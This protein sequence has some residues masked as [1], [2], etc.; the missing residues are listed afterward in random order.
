[1]EKDLKNLL[2]KDLYGR[3]PYG[4]I[5]EIKAHNCHDA[6]CRLSIQDMESFMNN[7]PRDVHWNDKVVSIK[8]YLLPM[9]SMSEEHRKEYV[10]TF[11]SGISS[12]RSF[13]WLNEHHYDYRH[14]IDKSL[15]IDAT[16]LNVY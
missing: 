5:V 8:P 11:E 13:D 2:L 10:S 1:M 6:I 14:L 12:C 15:A 9:S 3:F 7:Q 4:V 16:N